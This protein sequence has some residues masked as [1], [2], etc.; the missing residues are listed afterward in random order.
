MNLYSHTVLRAAC[1]LIAGIAILAIGVQPIFIGL[2][3]ER[4]AL[5]LAQQSAVMS[6][7]MCGS[8]L[9]T[10][11]CMP[12]MRRCSVRRVAF[13]AALALLGGNL[14][15][16]QVER[17]ESLVAMRFVCGVGC[18]VLYAYA[19]YGLGCLQGPARSYGVLLFL[20][21]GLFALVAALLPMIAGRLGF[22]WA[23]GY[24]AAWF[25]PVCLACFCLP[26]AALGPTLKGAA[27][28]GER[29]TLA[30]ALS[31]IGM[32]LLQ[33]SIY[34]LWGFVE[35][36]GR[37]AGI[38]SVDIGEAVSIG[39]LGGLPGAALPSLL[40]ERLGR[41]PMILC[42]S[43]LV[44]LS[45]FMFATRIHSA[46]DLGLAVFLMNVGWNLALSYYMS[47]IVSHDPTGTLTRLIGAVQVISGAAAPTL[48]MLF[49]RDG[50]RQTIF[51][52]SAGAIVLGCLA[53]LL[54]AM[55]GFGYKQSRSNV[56][57]VF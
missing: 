13:V 40:G 51:L 11:A 29:L 12:L 44:L 7:E 6:A 37:N 10:L 25:I 3:V 4:L 19:I 20:Q 48:L 33:L 22:S 5:S 47:S 50:G 38:T 24:L 9:G 41:V 15:T 1:I 35:G 39:L 27:L 57:K 16:A 14:L 21:T 36:V 8:I 49:M 26:R 17:L 31:L 53:V 2:L 30:G 52:L 54:I 23:I 43:L 34:S 45:I 46:V 32:V 18:G 56:Q 28:Q 42:G 55:M